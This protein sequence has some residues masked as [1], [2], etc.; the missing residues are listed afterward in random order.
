MRFNATAVLLKPYSIASL[1]ADFQIDFGIRCLG[2]RV[3]RQAVNRFSSR[4]KRAG[5]A[6]RFFLRICFPPVG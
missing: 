3:F 6:R 2:A 5:T 1:A 4:D